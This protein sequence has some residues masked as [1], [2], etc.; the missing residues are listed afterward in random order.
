A[1]LGVPLREYLGD[2][3][4]EFEITPNL[5]HNFSV[6]GVARE[7]AALYDTPL[8]LPQLADLT[9]LPPGEQGLVTIADTGLCPRYAAVVFDGITI[10]SSPDWLARRLNA[11]GVRPINNVVDVTNYVMLETGQP[12]HAF[13]RH[14]LSEGRI[15]VR[16]AARGE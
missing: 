11:A 12:L 9:A 1:P 10:E 2:T 13:D 15:V 6:H 8:S 16:T 14:K 4:I 7:D 3:V 5:V